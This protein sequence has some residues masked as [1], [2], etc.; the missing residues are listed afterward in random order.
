MEVTFR[1]WLLGLEVHCGGLILVRLELWALVVAL[2]LE[3]N[4]ADLTVKF[5][6]CTEMDHWDIVLQSMTRLLDTRL[7]GVL[8]ETDRQTDKQTDNRQTDRQTDCFID[9]NLH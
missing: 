4:C 9:L 1:C 6:L 5:G 3:P 8:S 2:H 7:L